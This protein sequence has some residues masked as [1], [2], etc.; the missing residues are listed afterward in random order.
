MTS[1]FISEVSSFEGNECP[2]FD[3][4]SKLKGEGEANTDTL[5]WMLWEY[6]QSAKKS[7]L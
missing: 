2:N 3:P 4:L 5:I 6:M 1:E 7:G